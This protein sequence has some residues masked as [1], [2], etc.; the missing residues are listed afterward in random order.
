MGYKSRKEK[1]G[2]STYFKKKKTP[3]KDSQD[4]EKKEL[5]DVKCRL[6]KKNWHYQSDCSK[7]KLDL[8]RKIIIYLFY[9]SNQIQLK[10]IIIFDGSILML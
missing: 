9:I 2:K 10:F 6:C 1:K 4:K 8:K 5:K 3:A 7:K